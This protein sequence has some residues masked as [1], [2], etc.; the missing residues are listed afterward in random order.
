MSYEQ[1]RVRAIRMVVAECEARKKSSAETR[2]IEASGTIVICGHGDAQW[3]TPT[4]G[5]DFYD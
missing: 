4:K 5:A 3:G 2:R 1:H